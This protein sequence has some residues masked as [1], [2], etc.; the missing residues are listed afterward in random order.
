M[1]VRNAVIPWGSGVA[2]PETRYTDRFRRWVKTR[3]PHASIDKRS[4]RFNSG[5]SD[6]EIHLNGRA[7]LIEVKWIPSVK[8]QRKISWRP[9]QQAYLEEKAQ[10]GIETHVLIGTPMGS[11][12]YE[13]NQTHLYAR[14]VREDAW[15]WQMLMEQERRS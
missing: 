7:I 4:D 10:A 8:Q 5:M 2:N 11:A 15:T 14:D 6:L 1:G 12:R 13:W 3:Y 9:L